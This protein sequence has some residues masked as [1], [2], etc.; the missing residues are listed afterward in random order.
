MGEDDDVGKRIHL[1]LEYS[2]TKIVSLRAGVN[3]GYLTYGLG[4]DTKKVQFDLL[5]YAEEVGN[6]SGQQKDRR[7]LLRF[8]VA[9]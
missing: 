1:G 5:S 9:F 7:Y 6:H 2:L 3:Q 8:G 4:A